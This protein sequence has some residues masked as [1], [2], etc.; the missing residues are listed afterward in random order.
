MVAR[1]APNLLPSR[2]RARDQEPLL[3]GESVASPSRSWQPNRWWRAPRL[4]HS[5]TP[6]T[7]TTLTEI[8]SRFVPGTRWTGDTKV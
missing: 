7:R 1:A 5:W 6:P 3:R 4:L 8:C 2:L